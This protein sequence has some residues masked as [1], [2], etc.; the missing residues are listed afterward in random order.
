MRLR[1]FFI[2]TCASLL[3]ACAVGPDFEPPHARL[4]DRWGAQ[5]P[6]ANE[7]ASN[8]RDSELEQQWWKQFND[9]TLDELIDAARHTNL[10]ARLA[11]LR[12]AQSRMRRD[13]IAGNQSPTVA[14]KAA[15]QRQ[16]QSEFGTGTR[17]IDAI[18]RAVIERV[19]LWRERVSEQG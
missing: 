14:A 17:L 19:L 13:V 3:C 8:I 7:L 5:M 10:D 2:L 18:G 4:P 6:Q 15:Y 11:A 9:A 1:S 16:R 12:V